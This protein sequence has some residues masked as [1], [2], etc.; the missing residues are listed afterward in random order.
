MRKMIYPDSVGL[1]DATSREDFTTRLKEHYGVTNDLEL[2]LGLLAHRYAK[3]DVSP[4]EAALDGLLGELTPGYYT[5]SIS[6]ENN[7]VVE[8]QTAVNKTFQ[9]ALR[10][11]LV[12]M[13]VKVSEVSRRNAFDLVA[14]D[15]RLK[16]ELKVPSMTGG[17]LKSLRERDAKDLRAVEVTKSLM[18]IAMKEGDPYGWLLSLGFMIGN[19]YASAE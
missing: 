3:L 18:A 13:K 17:K 8:A 14:K 7:T 15:L 19:E 11:A 1:A 4:L 12:D 2:I 10:L 5:H 6:K 16:A 9:R